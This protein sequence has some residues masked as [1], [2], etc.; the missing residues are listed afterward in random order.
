MTERARGTPWLALVLAGACGEAPENGRAGESAA[1][2]AAELPERNLAWLGARARPA[3]GLLRIPDG[4]HERCPGGLVLTALVA[5]GPLQVA[6]AAPGDVLVRVD[7]DWIPLQEDPTGAFLALVEQRISGGRARATLAVWRAPRLVEL[8][9]ELLDTALEVGLPVSVE[10]FRTAAAAAVEALLASEAPGSA[11]GAGELARA[12]WTSL[13]LRS[14]GAGQ[15]SAPESWRAGLRRADE[16]LRAELGD[17]ALGAFDLA[18]ATLALAEEIGPLPEAVCRRAAPRVLK[19]AAPAGAQS[20]GSFTITQAVQVGGD[21]ESV[22]LQALLD[23]LDEGAQVMTLSAEDLDGLELP[24]GAQLVAPGAQGELPEGVREALARS[25]QEAPAPE[26]AAL[27]AELAPERIPALAGLAGPLAALLALQREDGSCAAEG[28]SEAEALVVDAFALAALGAA[29]RVGRELERGPLERLAA[30]LRGAVDDGKVASAVARGADRRTLA[31]RAGLVAWAFL[32]AGCPKSDPFVRALLDY[33]D[34]KGRHL[35]ESREG[36]GFGLL[37]TAAVRR[38]R[39]LSEWQRFYDEFR[40]A[41]VAWQATDGSFELPATGAP[42]GLDGLW[43]D[44]AAA[45]ALGAL[46]LA[47]QE[48]RLPVLVSAADNP[49]APRLDSATLAAEVTSEGDE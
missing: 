46:V 7:E 19:L 28:A 38:G 16:R 15:E 30:R 27:L 24:E 42:V 44:R 40:L 21:G 18:L 23:G 6:R 10:R 13:A 45:T 26:L 39:G 35:L 29:Q 43:R 14:A 12:A 41:L 34:D 4:E 47:L 3:S 31:A 25:T 37:A 48:E 9:L 49:F 8:D 22:D 32:S 20:A 5:G 17:P 36:L 11:S 2:S 33:S 1:V